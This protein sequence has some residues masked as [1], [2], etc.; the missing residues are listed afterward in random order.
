[1]THLNKGDI[2]PNFSQKNQD[3]ELISLSDLKGS[4]VI[5]YFYPKDNTP[6]CTTQAC[7]LRDNALKLS[8]ENYITIGVSPDSEKSHQKFITKFDL[9]FDLLSDT[10][11]TVIDAYGVWGPKQ[12]M[13]KKYDGIHRTTFIINEE[14]V[15]ENIIEKVKTKAH[16]EQ[17]LSE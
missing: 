1:M 3:G 12:F 4:K 14:G 7:N 5:L 10:D 16:T 6:G 15:I 2:A 17:I 11:K 13:G 9:N 8:D